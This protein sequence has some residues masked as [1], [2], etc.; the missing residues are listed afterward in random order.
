ME[1][2]FPIFIAP[3]SIG[4]KFVVWER[5]ADFE[6]KTEFASEIYNLQ[7]VYAIEEKIRNIVDQ[8]ENLPINA[9]PT[10]FFYLVDRLTYIL[11]WFAL[12][13]YDV[14]KV[15]RFVIGSVRTRFY[16]ELEDV[17]NVKSLKEMVIYAT[18]AHPFPDIKLKAMTLEV[19]SA[20]KVLQ[21]HNLYRRVMRLV[22]KNED[23][24]GRL[25]DLGWENKPLLYELSVATNLDDI[26]RRFSNFERVCKKQHTFT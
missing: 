7:E 24:A 9:S 8:I 13:N 5:D 3:L 16:S 4:L 10:E 22:R 15:V 6:S 12:L 2:I 17:A 14:A 23:L 18:F 26:R 25:N 20:H 21:T 11:E 19:L 1:E